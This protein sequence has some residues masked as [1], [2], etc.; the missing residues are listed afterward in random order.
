[1]TSKY[2]LLIC[3]ISIIASKYYPQINA[4]NI[5]QSNSDIKVRLSISEK[6]RLK[7]SSNIKSIVFPNAINESLPGSPTLPSKIIYV[8]IPPKSL[9]SVNLT[10]Q[11]YNI[12]SNINVGVNPTVLLTNDSTLTY[13]SGNLKKEFFT[14]DQYPSVECKVL[15]YTWMSNYYCAIIQINDAIYNWKLKQVKLLLSA[16]LNIIYK[17]VFAFPINTSIESIYEKSLKNIIINYN[18]AKNFRSFRKYS[19]NPDTTGNWIDFTK[20]YV[21]LAI[22]SDGIYHIGYQNLLNYGLNPASIDPATIKIFCNGHELPSYVLSNQP[23]SFSNGDYIEFWAQKNY[24]S[25]NYR[26]IVPTGTDY[27]NYMDRYTD[28]TFIW[29]TWNGQSGHRIKIDST[30]NSLLIDSLTSY[31]NF[32]H[33]ENDLRLWYYD[34]V[35][36]R[37]QLPHW[38][39]NKVWTWN[40]LGTNSTI[41]L[42]FQATNIVPNSL[43]KTYVRLI[44]N[45]TD[46]QTSAHK[47]GASINTNSIKDSITFNFM[48]A[49]NLFST[50]P[51]NVINNG[52]NKLNITDL[53][54]DATFQQILLDWVDIEYYRKLSA[55]NDSLYFKFPDSLSTKFRKIIITN[56]TAS[57]SNLALYKV[58][59]DTV[60]FEKFSLSGSSSKT[61]T[62]TDTV[63]GGNAYILIANTYLQFP[64]FV[65][66][67]Q[68]VNLRTNPQG[69]DDI[70]ISNKTLEKSVSDYYKFIKNNY[71]IRVDLSFINDIYDEFSFGYPKPEAIKSFL[72]YAN[73]NWTSPAP[74]YLTLIGDANYDYK[75]SQT[76]VPAIKKQ[77]LVPSY[78]NPVSDAWFCIWDS[79]KSDIPQMFIGRIPAAN[80]QQ[81]YFYLNKY[82]AYVAKPYDEWNKTF[83][84]FSGGDPTVPGQI[85]QLKSEND[86]IFKTMVRSDPIGGVGN[87]FYKTINPLTN[88]GP[89]NRTQIQNAIEFGGLFI[90]YIGHSGTQTWDNGITDVSA[91]KNTYLNRF[92]LISD[93]GCS[94]GKFAEPDVNCFGELFISGSSEGQAIAYLSNSSWG[95]I[96]TAIN[97]PTFFYNQFLKDSIT[98]ISEAHLLAKV[99]VLQQEGYSDVNRVFEYDNILFGDPLINLKIPAKPNLKISEADIQLPYNNPSD[100][101]NYLPVKIYYHNYGIV[102]NDSIIITIK[103]SYNSKV[104][105]EQYFKRRIPQII[106]SL[107]VNIPIKGMNGLH[108]LNVILDSTNSVFEIYENDNQASVNYNVNSSSVRSLLNNQFYNS[109]NGAISFLNPANIANTADSSFILQLDTTNNFLSPKQFSQRFGVFSTSINVTNLIPMKNYWWRAKIIN[110]SYW[111]V[112]NSFTNNNSEYQW[113]I[114]SPVDST[115]DLDYLNTNYNSVDG[116]WELSS[117]KDELKISSA[118]S[119]D[120]EFASMQYNF[121]E[122]L[123]STYFWGIAT[124]IIDSVSLKPLNFK[125]F[126]YPN[127][128]AGDSLLSY[129]KGLPLGTVLAMAICAD[130]AQSV[131]G[132]SGG[133]PVRNEIKNWGSY[134]IDSI[135]YRDSWC[136]IGKKGALSGSVPEVYK[137]Q[138][139]GVAAI[140]TSVIVKNDS[141]SV[142]FPVIKN[143]SEWDSLQI[144]AFVPSGSKMK[145][146]AIGINLNNGTDTLGTLSLTNGKAPLNFINAKDYPQLQFVASFKSNQL[147]ESPKL[148]SAAVK[149]KSIPELG[150]NY[151]VVSISNDSV[152][153]GTK[154]NLQFFVYNVGGSPADSF[155]V[156]VDIVSPDNSKEIIDSLFVDCLNP[157]NSRLFNVSYIPTS[158][159]E[160]FFLINIDPNNKVQEVYKDNNIFR[161]AFSVYIDSL[162]LFSSASVSF[163]FDGNN[164]F[165]GDYVSAN[166]LIEFDVKYGFNYPYKD[167]SKIH[168]FIDNNEILHSQMDTIIYDSMN[169]KVKYFVHSII[170]DGQHILSISGYNLIN[171]LQDLQRI[172]YVSTGLKMMNILNYPNPFKS[173]TYFTFNLTELPDE[174]D[175]RIYTVGGR[176]IRQIKI[177]SEILRNNFNKI[178]WDGRDEDGNLIAS[179]AYF[180]KISAKLSGK[181]Y[182]EIN[183]LAIVR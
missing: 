48:Q 54:T 123:P 160:N 155:Y 107:T 22:P 100:Q 11:Q 131:I 156:S 29:L 1:M 43:L 27:L 73:E 134:Y 116:A 5:V 166:P 181:T 13:H 96:S 31:L 110:S 44:S 25:Q 157:G 122:E 149:L 61:L 173:F 23:G 135:R 118:G 169:M 109:F 78:G 74:S 101:T 42:P 146:T 46:I 92:P 141:G 176:L 87:H 120:G 38:Q 68:F 36:P 111:S 115:A 14:S 24:G 40:V 99:Q 66:K 55:I 180:Y 171:Q 150:T 58:F 20:Q 33:F 142:E 106:D 177:P 159:G 76:P 152:L 147:K 15:G 167:S 127:P 95:Y 125:T 49:A 121:H 104:S 67:K 144:N 98:N 117:K 7:D 64:I 32:Q 82:N 91:L 89:Y 179:G 83:L 90:S 50:F 93:F 158:L 108:M 162:S 56:I 140:D 183:K 165:N 112:P 136:I 114:N 102:P 2:L 10:D 19:N 30:V 45:A 39:E 129:L 47:V 139:D 37:V 28:T 133:T 79:N 4:E 6:Y 69:S 18:D 34:S 94:T 16:N 57:E 9:V 126:V 72:I 12:F 138:F 153:V 154:E 163:T 17:T 3:F 161:K 71:N 119:M 175:I 86:Y 53:P 164:I 21:K 81:V 85:D 130:G 41:S 145:L 178:Y 143:S 124:A 51:S 174:M 52:T 182:S 97:F 70:V 148:Y 59:P 8:A 105:Y 128:P 132:Y 77:N 63:S 84:F 65:E 88:Y 62:F 137:K 170:K 60:K 75:N 172:F 103:D 35:V 26:Q 168:F 113:F 80:D 151:Q